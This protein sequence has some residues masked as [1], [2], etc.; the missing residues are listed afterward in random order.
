M[1]QLYKK[2]VPVKKDTGVKKKNVT[3]QIINCKL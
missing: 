2:V 3:N 1:L